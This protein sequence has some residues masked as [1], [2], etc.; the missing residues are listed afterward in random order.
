MSERRRKEEMKERGRE[1]AA[2]GSSHPPRVLC[3]DSCCS[4]D[5]PVDKKHALH[6]AVNHFYYGVGKAYMDLCRALTEL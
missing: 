4:N 6:T 3:L 2:T 1:H 5:L